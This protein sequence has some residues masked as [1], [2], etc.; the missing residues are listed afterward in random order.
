[1]NEFPEHAPVRQSQHDW[2]DER[3][4]GAQQT[5]Q[6]T[7]EGD[8]D[9]HLTAVLIEEGAD[10]DATEVLA[11]VHPVDADANDTSDRTGFVVV[12][13]AAREFWRL[14][15]CERLGVAAVRVDV[16]GERGLVG[17]SIVCHGITYAEVVN[18]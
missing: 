2:R 1:M 12:V 7:L 15:E 11:R 14:A 13:G 3:P 6:A 10:D 8:G 5:P 4:R 9:L 16:V 18:H 17:G